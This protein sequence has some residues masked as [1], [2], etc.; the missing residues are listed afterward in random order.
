MNFTFEDLEIIISG[1]KLLVDGILLLD[2]DPQR[3][4]EELMIFDIGIT[5]VF[6]TEGQKTRHIYSNKGVKEICD[7]VEH[8][9]YKSNS[10]LYNDALTFWEDMK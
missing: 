4:E 3:E 1:H 10:T 7:A 5:G 8:E 2:I 9:F 6:D